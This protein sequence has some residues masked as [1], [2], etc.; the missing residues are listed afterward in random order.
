M[1]LSHLP[2]ST[3]MRIS[4]WRVPDITHQDGESADE[5]S[6]RKQEKDSFR[7]DSREHDGLLFCEYGLRGCKGCKVA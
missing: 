3:G 1:P 5:G 4:H 6:E 2:Y 7:Q